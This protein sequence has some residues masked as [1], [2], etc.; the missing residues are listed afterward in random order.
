[1]PSPEYEKLIET[2]RASHIGGLVPVSEIRAKWEKFTSTFMIAPDVVF[3]PVDANGVE[4]EWANAPD[5][6]PN[7]IILFFHGGGY[8]IGTIASYRHFVARIARAARAKVLSVGYR[9]A[10][11][12]PFPAALEDALAS[13]RWLLAQGIS[14]N[15]VAVGGDSAGGGLSLALAIANRDAKGPNPAAIFVISPS[16]DLAKEGEWIRTRAKLD[17]LVNYEV[18][19]ALAL[20]YVGPSGNLKEP[21]ASPLYA[22]MHGLPPLLIMVGT[23]DP[24]LEDA[25][26]F[27]TKAQAAGVTV[28]LDISDQMFHIWPFFAEL[29]PEGREAIEKIG[30]YVNARIT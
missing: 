8:N 14:P 28:E 3:E 1:M 27:A 30:A 19:M 25:T 17:P 4:A 26:R 13:Y 18:S 12:H 7:R 15:R 9:L 11:E 23:L 29:I 20:S 10:P 21:L 16:T 24:L 5:S 6:D 2:L 22:E